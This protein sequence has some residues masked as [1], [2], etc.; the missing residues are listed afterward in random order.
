MAPNMTRGCHLRFPSCLG[1]DPSYLP[2]LVDVPDNELVGLIRRTP[3]NPAAAVQA[4]GL[5]ITPASV[6]GCLQAGKYLQ[7]VF[8]AHAESIKRLTWS[9]AQALSHR[10]PFKMRSRRS[11]PDCELA[12]DATAE[13]ARFLALGQRRETR[14]MRVTTTRISR[15]DW[16][17]T[18]QTALK[19]QAYSR[20][21]PNLPVP[22]QNL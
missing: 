18:E 1:N 7:R 14:S 9:H 3:Q 15:G 11:E 17:L 8:S 22:S 4:G 20:L 21:V 6:V 10:M 16:I 13:T 2:C 12:D 5:E 19:C